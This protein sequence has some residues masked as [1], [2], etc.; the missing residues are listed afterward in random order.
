VK[1]GIEIPAS[2]LL[3]LCKP[4][5]F[6]VLTTIHSSL[7]SFWRFFS[8]LYSPTNFLFRQFRH[9]W[10]W[11]FGDLLEKLLIELFHFLFLSKSVDIPPRAEFSVVLISDKSEI[12]GL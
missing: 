1:Q 6:S 3:F 12:G 4:S 8:I 11:L 7:I 10:F 2:H 9:S 5:T